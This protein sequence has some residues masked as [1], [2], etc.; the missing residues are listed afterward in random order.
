MNG[1]TIW[2]SFVAR[3]L[4]ESTWACTN[5]CPWRRATNLRLPKVGSDQ[6][7]A[8][9]SKQSSPIESRRER[10]MKGA[11]GLVI[12]PDELRS[13]YSLRE[14]WTMSSPWAPSDG[15][16]AS[17]FRDDETREGTPVRTE[18]TAAFRVRNVDL[19]PALEALSLR[20][21]SSSSAL[22]KHLSVQVIN[23][24]ESPPYLFNIGPKSTP[25]RLYVR[26]L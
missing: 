12:D 11:K 19:L 8:K 6:T 4:S 14:N 3:L 2:K 23:C 9:K 10:R 20:R 1:Q 7:P 16:E 26:I 21:W 15:S 25:Q 5:A 17:Q 24:G 18:S 22:H 13:L